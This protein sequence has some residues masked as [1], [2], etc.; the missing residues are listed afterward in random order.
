MMYVLEVDE[1]GDE[2]EFHT[3]TVPFRGGNGYAGSEEV[4]LLN[5][6]CKSRLNRH[7]GL[8]ALGYTKASIVKASQTS[9][10]LS[11][12]EA[13]KNMMDQLTGDDSLVCFST[14][15]NSS[16]HNCFLYGALV[17]KPSIKADTMSLALHFIP[18]DGCSINV[19]DVEVISS[20]LPPPPSCITVEVNGF[21]I[22]LSC[23][24][25][26]A[27]KL[28]RHAGDLMAN[29]YRYLLESGYEGLSATVQYK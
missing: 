21:F 13:K 18:K 11:R 1:C 9:E 8:Q 6:C 15:V 22:N 7:N 5:I 24:R 25:E 19:K 16:G 3:I 14:I 29:L 26:D 23:G 17:R 12:E 4:N 28:Q 27:A 10:N 2:F 20:L